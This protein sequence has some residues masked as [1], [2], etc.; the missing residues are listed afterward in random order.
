MA[1]LNKDKCLV[2]EPCPK[3]ASKEDIRIKQQAGK[4]PPVSKERE[5]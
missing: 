3:E 2:S 5:F 4:T 1:G